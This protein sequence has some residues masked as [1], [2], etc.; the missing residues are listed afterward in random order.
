MHE[1]RAGL[2]EQCDSRA[3]ACIC[4]PGDEWR[5][6][7]AFHCLLAVNLAA[8]LRFPL[9]AVPVLLPIDPPSPEK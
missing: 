4:W 9:C 6:A 3:F 2:C 1:K 5:L 7:C 8:A